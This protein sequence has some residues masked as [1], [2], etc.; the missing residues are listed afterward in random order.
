MELSCCAA[1]E[2]I[3]SHSCIRTSGDSAVSPLLCCFYPSLHP[4]TPPS[5]I[6]PLTEEL[7]ETSLSHKTSLALVP[8]ACMLKWAGAGRDG[9]LNSKGH[10]PSQHRVEHG[11][12]RQSTEKHP[13]QAGLQKTLKKL[14]AEV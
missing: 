2:R 7:L 1:D 9:G 5:A 8:S 14:V 10:R 13:S 4:H 12:V 6:H 3:I 11:W